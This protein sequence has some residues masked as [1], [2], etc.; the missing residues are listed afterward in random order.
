MN[1]KYFEYLCK[2][3][4]RQLKLH[5]A[6]KLEKYDGDTVYRDGYIYHKGTHPVLLV[7]HLDTVHKNPPKKFVYKNGALSSPSGIGGDD[8]CGVYIILDILKKYK[9][10]K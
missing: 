3:P 2:M 6:D 5:L 9:M 7:A 8:R 4:Q 10:K 1:R